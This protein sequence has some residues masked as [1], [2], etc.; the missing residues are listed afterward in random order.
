M[1]QGDMELGTHHPNP[2]LTVCITILQD[3]QVMEG[4]GGQGGHVAAEVQHAAEVS[5]S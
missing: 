4:V 2:S 1:V 3:E 5:G